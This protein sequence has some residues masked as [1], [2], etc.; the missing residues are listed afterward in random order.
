[1]ICCYSYLCPNLILSSSEHYHHI[2]KKK[3]HTH[4]KYT[5]K[6]IVSILT[7]NPSAPIPRNIFPRED[8]VVISDKIWSINSNNNVRTCTYMLL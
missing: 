1:M 8:I 2:N 6:K 7:T 4:T 3:P 5:F